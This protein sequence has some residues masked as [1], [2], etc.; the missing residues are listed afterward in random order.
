MYALLAVLALSSAAAPAQPPA[1]MA[2]LPLARTV[3]ASTPPLTGTTW[4]LVRLDTGRGPLTLNPGLE[5]PTLRLVGTSATITSACGTQTVPVTRSGAVLKFPRLGQGGS[6]CP[7]AQLSLHGDYLDL[8]RRTTRYSLQGPTL[9]LSAGT[10]RLVFQAAPTPIPAP[11]RPAPVKPTPVPPGGPMTQAP[12]PR[13]VSVTA[14]TL[15]GKA[16]PVPA[17]AR[18]RLTTTAGKVVLSG[19]LDCNTLTGQGTL[20]GSTLRLTALA[21]TRMLCPAA[22]AENAFLQLLRG[23][24]TLTVQGDTQTWRG[25]AGQVT[26]RDVPAVA[27]PAAPTGT[28][29]LIRLNGQPAPTLNKPVSMTFENG[30]IG[31]TDGCNSYG[32]QYTLKGGVLQVGQLVSTMMMCPDLDGPRLFSLFEL[33]PTLT[34]AGTTLTLKAD[35]QVWEFTRQP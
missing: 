3:P 28:F 6:A 15:N 11:G 23:P 20:T 24:L 35:G 31:G 26:L 33:N 21:S 4:T 10:G 2:Q 18:L 16:V 17:D 5:R 7:D 14:L 25:A 9:T 19:R 13:E 29:V 22:S 27:T 32:G 30:Q 12:A 1:T 34:Q 8:L